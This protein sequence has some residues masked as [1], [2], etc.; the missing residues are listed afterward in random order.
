MLGPMTEV[1]VAR[2]TGSAAAFAKLRAY[3]LDDPHA[4]VLLLVEAGWLAGQ[5]RSDGGIAIDTGA[6]TVV[7]YRGL[8]LEHAALPELFT[9]ALGR[10]SSDLDRDAQTRARI[11]QLLGLAAKVA[12]ALAP[13]SLVLESST[14]D[15]RRTRIR[16]DPNR[17]VTVATGPGQARTRA[18]RR[19]AAPA[20]VRCRAR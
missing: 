3:Q 9:A 17:A 18:R 19:A 7:E 10:A 5:G 8:A 12:L 20:R 6:T 11:L 2:S 15:R 1:E 16:I 14:P 4:Y 13:E